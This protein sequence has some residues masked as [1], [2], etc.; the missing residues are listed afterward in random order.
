MPLYELTEKGFI[1][2]LD[3]A[4][5]AREAVM[6][7]LHRFQDRYIIS[8]E[9]AGDRLIAEFE[10]ATPIASV[11]EE[12]R[13]VMRELSFE[14]MRYDAVRQAG[15]I[16]ELLVARALYASCIEEDRGNASDE[17]DAN[18]SWREDRERIFSSWEPER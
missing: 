15:H 16:R 4:V 3:P 13:T 2:N 6:K 9:Y 7:A 11:D 18:G 5:Y 8:Y 1:L 14:M 12:I 17:S 10:A